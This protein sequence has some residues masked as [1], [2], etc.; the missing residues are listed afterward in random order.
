MSLRDISLRVDYRTGEGDIVDEFY[1][2]CLQESNTYWRAV[3]YFSSHSLVLAAKGVASLVHRGGSM[4]LVASPW[5][6]PADIEAMKQGHVAREDVLEHA[7]LRTFDQRLLNE[8]TK[9]EEHR[10]SCLAWLIATGKLEIMIA[11]PVGPVDGNSLYHEKIGLFF[12]KDGNTVAFTGSPNETAGGLVSNFESIDVFWSWDDPHGRIV[13]KMNQ[14]SRLWDNTT[15]QLEVRKFPKAIEDKILRF[16]RPDPPN[17]DPESHKPQITV[18][19]QIGKGLPSIPPDVILR[20]YQLDAIQGWLDQGRKGMFVMATGSGKTITALS[21]VTRLIQ[22]GT[23]G[24]VVVGAPYQHLVDQWETEARRFGFQP[25]LAY[26]NTKKWSP[27]LS[28]QIVE[29][30][31][32]VRPVSMVIS[33]Y[34]TLCSSTFQSLVA[35]VKGPAVF[36]ADEAHHVGAS[37][38]RTK[39][40]HSIPWRLGLSATPNRWFDDEGTQAL[41]EFFGKTV[42][43]YGIAQAISDGRLT[44]YYYHPHLVSLTDEERD[45][46]QELSRKIA[47]AYA[48]R[49]D[50]VQAVRLDMLLRERAHLLNTAHNKLPLLKELVWQ[51]HDL[52]HALFYCAPGQLDE[53]LA[54]LGDQ[55][56]FLVHP[57]TAKEKP[58]ERQRLLKAFASGQLQALVAIRCLDEGVDVPATRTAFVLASSSNPREFIQRRGRILRLSPNKHSAVI[59]DMLAIPELDTDDDSA[60]FQAERNLVSRELARFKEF[61]STAVNHFQAYDKIRPLAQKY[62]L[63]DL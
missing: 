9:L 53:V 17:G 48:R 63:L 8:P 41:T 35:Q 26:Q 15:P 52:S 19:E 7:L 57:F 13:R 5:L 32:G 20:D 36:V 1:I 6:E 23:R 39:L 18:P 49:D 25:V 10:L 28:D 45:Q 42:A 16:Y 24:L 51:K 30:N 60:V 55:C 56:G 22:E 2:P 47:V 54:L 62:H 58:A 50:E 43:E 34:D 3:G 14:F 44:P 4:R 61:A 59:H 33:T 40:P 11:T 37:D 21:A 38:T 29:F 12:D 46:Y 31:M 27:I